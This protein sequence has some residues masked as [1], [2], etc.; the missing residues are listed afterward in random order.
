MYVQPSEQIPIPCKRC[1]APMR[2]EAQVAVLAAPRVL[3]GFCGAT[4]TLPAE[5]AERVR[6]LRTRLAQ[7]RWAE[8]A[9][10]A[11]AIALSR[12]LEMWKQHS[13]PMVLGMGALMLV[14]SGIQ[15]VSVLSGDLSP[16]TVARVVITPLGGIAVLAS[17]TLGFLWGMREY[18]RDVRPALEARPPR[19]EGSPLRCRACG[20]DLPSRG[21]EGF[22]ACAYC[23][24][25]NMVTPAIAQERRV[26]LDR[27]LEGFT[28]RMAGQRI[29]MDE[30]A[31]RYKRRLYTAMG[32]GVGIS[33]TLSLGFGSVVTAI[34]SH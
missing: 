4:E 12:T 34:V 20:G 6:A 33:L 10:E 5:P 9:E 29:R 22:V 2:E 23:N 32:I 8:Q 21:L 3:C 15:A 7:L 13:L 31:S 14:A 1:G 16:L 11:P 19:E 27:E 28:R 30:A 26:R 17:V 18:A 25:P 24:A